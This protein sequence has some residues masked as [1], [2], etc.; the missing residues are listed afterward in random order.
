MDT[1]SYGY[2]YGYT[3][4]NTRTKPEACILLSW[5]ILR[6]HLTCHLSGDVS[7]GLNPYGLLLRTVLTI[8]CCSR[9][10]TNNSVSELLKSLRELQDEL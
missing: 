2:G 6:S 4:L 9:L 1:C 7:D 8:L 5:V 3:A 10:G